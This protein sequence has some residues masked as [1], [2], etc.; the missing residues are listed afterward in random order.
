MTIKRFIISIISFAQVAASFAQI[1]MASDS[2]GEMNSLSQSASNPL[3]LEPSLDSY[4]GTFIHQFSKK[5]IVGDTLFTCG[6]QL[7][8]CIKIDNNTKSIENCNSLVKGY[9]QVRGMFI[10]KDYGSKEL[11]EEIFKYVDD[12]YSL[13]IKVGSSIISNKQQLCESLSKSGQWLGGSN[14]IYRLENESLQCIY[15]TTIP[16]WVEDRFL[17]VSYFNFITQEL[18]GKEVLMTYS[19]NKNYGTGF[20]RNAGAKRELKDVLTGQTILQ[21]DTLFQC[22][23]I[24]ADSKEDGS[25]IKVCCILEGKNTGKIAV[26]VVRLIESYNE[27]RYDDPNLL[28]YYISPNGEWTIWQD[29]YNQKKKGMLIRGRHFDVANPIGGNVIMGDAYRRIIKI[30]DL[31]SIFEDTKKHI[32]ESAVHQKQVAAKYYAWKT[33]KLYNL[34][35]KYGDKYGSLIIDKKIDI[36]MSPEMC[37]ESWGYPIRVLTGSNKLG[38]YTEWIYSNNRHIYFV[39]NKVVEIQN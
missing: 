27:D 6:C 25:G 31:K 8:N 39:N 5:N 38:D 26:N 23:D 1:K 30:E 19:G 15:F 17:P 33:Y 32:S 2:F 3:S 34:C 14:T 37:R 10:T 9:Y 13:N 28:N 20:Y 29:S 36:G 12:G 7:F 16:A 4:D 22:I 11:S 21:K 24:V 18:K 35:Q